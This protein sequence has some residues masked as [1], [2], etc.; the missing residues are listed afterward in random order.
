EQKAAGKGGM[1][2]SALLW[3]TFR[4]ARVVAVCLYGGAFLS[5]M[6]LDTGLPCWPVA[7]FLIGIACGTCVFGAEQ[8]GGTH[9]FLGDRR[10]PPGRV[11]AVKTGSWLVRA[12]AAALFV[13]LGQIV[14]SW[15]DAP[16]HSGGGGS[17]VWHF[18]LQQ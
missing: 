12:V 7:T 6:L 10:L 16:Q 1:G 15:V 8:I 5:G 11:W 18:A 3:L 17:R 9:R 14:L 4:Q 2:T 13:A